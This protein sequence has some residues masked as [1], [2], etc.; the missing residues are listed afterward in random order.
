MPEKNNKC[1]CKKQFGVFREDQEKC[2]VERFDKSMFSDGRN[3]E[4]CVWIRM[5]SYTLSLYAY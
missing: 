2:P 5:G 4:E 1:A 3:L